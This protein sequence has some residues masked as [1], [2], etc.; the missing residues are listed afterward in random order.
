LE[1][2]GVNLLNDLE[3]SLLVGLRVSVV[4]RAVV[5]LIHSLLQV[6]VLQS[7]NVS[8]QS[9]QFASR[10]QVYHHVNLILAQMVDLL[11]GEGSRSN[12]DLA[13]AFDELTLDLSEDEVSGEVAI[14]L[15]HD[16]IHTEDLV[17]V[18]LES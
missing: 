7:V 16:P 6:L 2:H 11:V 5:D 14:S 18:S 9:L 13:A 8:H 10:V 3:D 1:N 12:E 4:E 17:V 15:L